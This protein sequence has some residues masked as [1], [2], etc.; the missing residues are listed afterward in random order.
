MM[1]SCRVKVTFGFNFIYIIHYNAIY[2]S[3]YVVNK[4]IYEFSEF[5]LICIKYVMCIILL[6]GLLNA[7]IEINVS[8]ICILL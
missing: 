4:M 3:L 5:F 2:L 7:F 1:P 6:V 8:I